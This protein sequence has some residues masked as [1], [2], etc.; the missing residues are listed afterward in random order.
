[1]KKEYTNPELVIASYSSED[2][3]TASG[4]K[5]EATQKTFGN[6]IKYSDLSF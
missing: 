3:I 1:M 4:L 6:K 5:T 2:V